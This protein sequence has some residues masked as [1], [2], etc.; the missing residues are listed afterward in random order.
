MSCREARLMS[1]NDKDGRVFDALQEK[2]SQEQ[3]GELL[4]RMLCFYL[5]LLDAEEEQ[6][7][8]QEDWYMQWRLEEDKS[9]KVKELS[10]M[11]SNF[12]S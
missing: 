3:Y 4:G 11:H 7:Q 10:Y 2:R 1:R 12:T 8:E 9:M 6:E 5:R